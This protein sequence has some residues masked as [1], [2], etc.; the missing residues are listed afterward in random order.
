MITVKL[1]H[2]PKVQES[3]KIL[4]IL[5][6]ST[7]Y[8]WTSLHIKDVESVLNWFV[9]STD[10]SLILNA[11]VKHE[12]LDYNLLILL[13]TVCCMNSDN[14]PKNS[15][16]FQTFTSIT[17]K[18]MIYVRSFM[19]LL[20]S[21]DAKLHK[22]L[23]TT[24]GRNSF[25]QSFNSL[26]NLILSCF[27]DYDISLESEEVINLIITIIQTMNH[28]V[29]ESTLCLISEATTLWQKSCN[30]GNIVLYNFPN[31]L[32]FN[33]NWS[34]ST[35]QILESSICAFLRTYGM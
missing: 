12:T 1:S 15:E 23:S 11:S 14:I 8:P 4:Q 7:K 18:R 29:P 34:L 33:Q 20:I 2:E 10:S 19:R 13:Q 25:Y 26:M 28:S 3:I 17:A 5:Q 35:F 6:E 22:L 9:M 27:E 30:S 16:N 32:K 24:Q 31:A 21:C